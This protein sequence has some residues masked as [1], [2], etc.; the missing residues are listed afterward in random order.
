MSNTPS[1]VGGFKPLGLSHIFFGWF[2]FGFPF[3]TK[4]ASLPPEQKKKARLVHFASGCWDCTF[5]PALLGL[6]Y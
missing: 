1:V 6:P 2:P 5:L 4:R 3:G